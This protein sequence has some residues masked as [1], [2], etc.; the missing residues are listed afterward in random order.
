MRYGFR[1][2][3]TAPGLSAAIKAQLLA[4]PAGLGDL[5]PQSNA[6][7][8][9]FCDALGAA[10]VAYILANAVVNPLGLLAPPG[11]L[12]GPVTGTGSLL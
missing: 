11:T 3:L 7:M 5:K 10:I 2:P 4:A 6:A 9:Q 1:V 8:D 12:G